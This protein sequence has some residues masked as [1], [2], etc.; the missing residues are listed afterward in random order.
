MKR[1]EYKRQELSLQVELVKFQR[2]VQKEKQRL[3][4]IFEGR[5]AAGK[6]GTIIRFMQHLNP[7]HARA[8]A[9]SK[10]T[11]PSAASGIS[12]VMSSTF[13]RP[14][15]WS[16]SIALGITAPASSACSAFAP[17]QRP[18]S[19]LRRRRSLRRALCATASS[20]SRLWLTVSPEMPLQ[21]FPC[22]APSP[23][24]ASEP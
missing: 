16:C 7:R 22:S 11:E 15:T 20:S 21:R 23:I 18:R 1:K 2:W 6:G 3:V 5:D 10:P 9:L 14:A 13:P 19:F 24:D 8:V 4:I 12:S 17:R